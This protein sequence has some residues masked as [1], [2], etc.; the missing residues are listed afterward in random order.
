MP[1]KS[2]Q[3]QKF[4]GVVKAMQKGDI[5]NKGEAGDVA[6]DMDKKEVDKMTST[7]HKGLPRKIKEM[8]LRELAQELK[9]NEVKPF[10]DEKLVSQ[11]H[12]K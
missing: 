8:V 5:P 12:D 4:F 11:F 2:K 9:L 1:S 10:R 6:D 7:K 3:Q